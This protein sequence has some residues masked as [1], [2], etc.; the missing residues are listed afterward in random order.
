[1][2]NHES[3]LQRVVE[4]FETLTLETA[5]QLGKVYAADVSFKDPFNEVT[6][7]AATIRLFTHMFKQV[8]GLRFVMKTRIIQGNDAFMTWDFSF[9]MHYFS[10]EEQCIHGATHL[11]F[12]DAGLVSMHRDYWDT[13][14]EIYEKLPALGSLMRILKFIVNK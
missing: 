5:S 3:D 6:G 1:M 11:R 7:L 13:A 9:K 10:K 8:D 12:N 14:E 4:F 2:M